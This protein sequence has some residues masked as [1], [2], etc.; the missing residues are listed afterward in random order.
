MALPRPQENE[1]YTYADY[2]KWDDSARWE[3]IDGIPYAMAP[4]PS[5]D[6][7][8]M[9]GGI[10][11]QLY[12][13]LKG[14]PCDVFIAPSDVRLAAGGEDDTVVQPDL[15]VVCDKSK[16]DGQNCNGPPDLVIEILS[17]STSKHD[18]VVKFG[19][20]LRYG[21]K[22]YW[23]ADPD[24]KTLQVCILKDGEYITRMYGDEATAPVSVLPGC[25]IKLSEIFAE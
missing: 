14:K 23:I 18:R 1:R 10:Y 2:C 20:Y 8:Q 15:F 4:A 21:V 3:I 25:E 24:T 13:Y 6:H 22:E 7:Q 17:P 16:L 5:Q 12:S 11:V 19:L 9:C